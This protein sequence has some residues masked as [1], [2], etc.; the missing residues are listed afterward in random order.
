MCES[1]G[2]WSFIKKTRWTDCSIPLKQTSCNKC[3]EAKAVQVPGAVE[4]YLLVDVPGLNLSDMLVAPITSAKGV[5]EKLS[6][7]ENLL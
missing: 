2:F 4:T 7:I 3:T 6:F 1:S 5:G